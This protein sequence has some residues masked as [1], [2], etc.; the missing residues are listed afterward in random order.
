MEDFV[1]HLLYLVSQQKGRSKVSPHKATKSK[2]HRKYSVLLTEQSTI[3]LGTPQSSPLETKRPKIALNDIKTM[4]RDAA[5]TVNR[6]PSYKQA[7]GSIAPLRQFDEIFILDDSELMSGLV[8]GGVEKAMSLWEMLIEMLLRKVTTTVSISN[9]SS[10]T[11]KTKSIFEAGSRSVT[12]ENQGF[13]RQ[14]LKP[15]WGIK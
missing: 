14:D 4:D 3:P 8:A 13:E 10:M 5:N 11:T 7:E 2:W 15:Y 12:K 9:S 1:N 6:P